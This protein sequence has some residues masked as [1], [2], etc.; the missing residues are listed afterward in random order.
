MRCQ[1]ASARRSVLRRHPKRRRHLPHALTPGQ[2]RHRAFVQIH[3]NR[4]GRRPG[5]PCRRNDR[6]STQDN[7]GNPPSIHNRVIVL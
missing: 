1:V 3:R 5:L 7:Q 2:P 6:E 4:T